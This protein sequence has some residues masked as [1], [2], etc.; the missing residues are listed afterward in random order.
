M[1]PAFD[2]QPFRFTQAY[3][4]DLGQ[5][6]AED[7]NAAAEDNDVTLIR[8]YNLTTCTATSMR[9]CATYFSADESKAMETFVQQRMGE[10]LAIVAQGC[11]AQLNGYQF[12]A[13]T[14]KPTGGTDDC[15][16]A[17]A[18][19]NC[20]LRDKAFPFCKCTTKQR[21]TPFAVSTAI[22]TEKGRVTNS[23]LYCFET[24]VIEPADPNVSYRCFEVPC[25][26]YKATVVI[27]S[28][29]SSINK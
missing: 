23:T 1:I 9:I 10:W 8:S 26:N 12:Q 20:A 17:E 27:S 29:S 18:V 16:K 5:T 11:P 15:M 25:L 3:C 21:S 22:R 7:L 28:A 6:I 19:T 14:T 13:S 2:P 24:M 4:N